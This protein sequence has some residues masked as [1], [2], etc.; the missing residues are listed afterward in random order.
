[1]ITYIFGA[2]AS[3]NAVPVVRDI[4]ESI[5]GLIG[6]LFKPEF[7]SPNELFK[8]INAGQYY[9]DQSLTQRFYDENSHLPRLEIKNLLKILKEKIGSS[10][11]IDTV[12]KR[13]FLID[14]Q[15]HDY[16]QY[17]RMLA[18]WLTVTQ[19]FNKPDPRYE[20]FLATVLDAP[21]VGISPRLNLISWNYDLQFEIAYS[22]FIKERGNLKAAS[23]ILGIQSKH[24]KVRPRNSPHTEY[25]SLFKVNGTSSFRQP[26]KGRPFDYLVD[27]IQDYSTKQ[28]LSELWINF[29]QKDDVELSFAW[30]E[31]EGF[32]KSIE[33]YSNKIETSDA[34]VIIG[35]SFPTFNR[36]IDQEFMKAAKKKGFPI[37]VQDK[38]PNPIKDKLEMNFGISP[39]RIKLVGEEN[40][41]EFFIPPQYK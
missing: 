27:T 22:Q 13:L 38:Y 32:Q 1:M 10:A 37:Y 26:E 4:P 7:Y 9:F 16:K 2:G 21:N 8:D 11:S 33:W 14:P 12:A 6:K 41:T 25:P 36:M 28:F 20:L 18:L 17:K 29:I 24:Q 3:A 31:S 5:E 30:E 19:R 40:I 39:S 23:E 34:L 35:Y 15:S